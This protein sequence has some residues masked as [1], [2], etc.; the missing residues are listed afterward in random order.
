M[1][2]VYPNKNKFMQWLVFGIMVC[3]AG[4]R[5]HVGIDYDW[6]LDWYVNKSRDDK[7]EYGFLT[8]MML[9]RGLNFSYHTFFFFLSFSTI[10][11]A[12][13][14]VKNY[15]KNSSVAFLFFFLIPEL[16][17][18]SFNLM[19]QS[20]SVCVSFYAFYFLIHKKYFIFG[21][22]MFLA[23]S[24]HNSAILP[25]FVFLIVYQFS[26]R[27]N[28]KHIALL[29]IVSLAL[30]YL[31][32]IEIFGFIFKNTHYSYYFESPR[33]RVSLFKTIVLNSVAFFVLFYFEKMK[34]RYAYQKYVMVLF[35][36]TVIFMNLF[37]TF[38]NVERLTYF[39]KIFEI[40]VVADLIFVVA[41]ERRILLFSCFFVYYLSLFVHTLNTDFE[42]KSSSK[43][44]P[45]Q[46]FILEKR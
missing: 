4:F 7:L 9:F 26:D 28:A 23:L 35:F 27:I 44:I 20:F 22:L 16:Y 6:Y 19:R 33:A 37:N 12:F 31:N 17:L 36:C 45:Y 2:F 43:L 10:L 29:L 8:L 30:S 42:I 46:T 14:G 15:T 25:L 34:E 5:H 1:G 40:I 39:F 24:V 18:C 32:V 3:V 13:L 11:L 21:L 41:K 38:A